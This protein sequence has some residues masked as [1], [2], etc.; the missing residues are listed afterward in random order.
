MASNKHNSMD[1]YDCYQDF[2]AKAYLVDRYPV[3]MFEEDQTRLMTP[4]NILCYHRFYQTFQREW[5]NSNAILL[6]LGG[7]PCIYDF[8]S[9]APYVAEIYHSDYIKNCCDEVL[10]WRNRDSNA[11]DW[12]PYFRYVVNI[13]EGKSDPNAVAEREMKLRCTLRNSF[14]CNIKQSPIVPGF[15]KCPNIICANFCLETSL[16]SKDRYN[17]ALK[18]IF[19]MLEPKGFFVMLFSL[20]C[21]WY[22]FNGT[23]FSCIYLNTRDVEDALK[24]VGFV[25]RFM[26][27]REKPF[28]GRNISNDTTGQAFVVAQKVTA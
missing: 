26:E 2:D 16:S 17:A 9:A 28:S 3:T 15:L 27:S 12:S 18:E 10:L 6:E 25:V 24:K 4:W 11:Y 23:K 14:T 8:I 13:L 20:G 19:E 21:T 5:D 22:T 1:Y 7:G